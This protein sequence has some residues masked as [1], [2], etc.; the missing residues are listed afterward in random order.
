MRPMV[1]TGLLLILLLPAAGSQ[2]YFGFRFHQIKKDIKRQLKQGVPDDELELL[3]IP[4][5]F[6]TGADPRFERIHAREFRYLGRM[7]DIVRQE[8]RGDTT[9]YWCIHDFRESA[10]FAQLDGLA[11]RPRMATGPAGKAANACS[12]FSSRCIWL[13]SPAMK[14]ALRT[15]LSPAPPQPFVSYC[16]TATP[17]RP[18]RRPNRPPDPVSFFTTRTCPCRSG[19]TT[20]MH[21]VCRCSVY[22]Y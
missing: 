7:Y 19:R 2:L 18:P 17:T 21:P 11:G 6:E 20:P 4:R 15:R 5:S 9:W 14:A 1:A 16:R 8:T 12:G 22:L 3:K 13:S 10:L